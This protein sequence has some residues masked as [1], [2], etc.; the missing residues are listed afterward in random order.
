MSKVNIKVLGGG[1][2]VGRSAILLK[3]GGKSLLLDYGVMLEEDSPKFPLNYPP[4]L[5]DAII[6]THAHLDHSGA[7][8]MLYISTPRPLYATKMTL[9]LSEVLIRDFIKISGYYIPYEFRDFRRMVKNAVLVKPEEEIYL[10]ELLLRFSDAGHIPGSINVSISS[11]DTNVLYTGDFNMVNTCLLS[12]ASI[13]VKDADVIIIEG[14][15]AIFNHPKR[16][17]VEKDFVSDVIEVIENDGNVLIPAF[18]VGRAQEIMCVLAKYNFDYKV[19]LDGMARTVAEILLE[20]LEFLRDPRLF[21]RAF[22]KTTIVRGWE[23]R[24]NV[25]K[26]PCVIVSPAGMLK[27]GASVYYLRRLNK[28]KRN[29][30]FFVSYQ[31]KGT[32]GREI[33]EEGTITNGRKPV[34]VKAKVKWFDFSSHCGKRELERGLKEVDPST[35]VIIVHSEKETGEI[36]RRY[37][38]KS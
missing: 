26:Q 35:K 30:I 14:T 9:S 1:Q 33:L 5:I 28:K 3:I 8:P 29:A 37:C 2:E 36:F 12:S 6:L 38:E 27:G 24:R 25:I 11:G 20:G 34:K 16:E 21:K 15:Y 17:R 10:D 18:A 32:P 31:S 23:D 4:K 7:L 19:Y 22:K 13:N